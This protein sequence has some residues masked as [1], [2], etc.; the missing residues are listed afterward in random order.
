MR[1]P[2]PAVEIVEFSDPACPFAFSAEPFRWKLRWQFGHLIGCASRMV[3]LAGS[4]G[5]YLAKGMTAEIIAGIES[6]LGREHGMPIDPTVKAR[7]A[8]TR[9]A[10][11]AVVA[12]RIHAP[13]R[14]L[15]L[16]R[17]LRVRNFSGELLDDPATLAGAAADAGI[18]PEALAA[19]MSGADVAAAV[20]RDMDD[21]RHPSP[22]ALALDHKLA[23]WGGNGASGRRYTCPSLEISRVADGA[24]QSAPGL[25]PW[26][27]YE[28]LMANGL[29]SAE[30]RPSPRDV[31]EPPALGRDGPG[32]PGGRDGLRPESRRGARE[33]GRRRC[34]RASDRRRRLLD[35]RL[36]HRGGRRDGRASAALVDSSCELIRSCERIA[37]VSESHLVA[38]AVRDRLNAAREAGDSAA[39]I[40]RRAGCRPTA[41]RLLVLRALSS[42]DHVSA[43]EVLAHARASYPAINP[44]TVYRTLDALAEAGLVLCVD[45]GSGRRHYEI[46]REHRHHHVVCQRCGAVAHLHDASLAPLATALRADSGYRLV[47]DR[48]IAMPGVCP[49]CQASEEDGEPRDGDP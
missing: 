16:L 32:E 31:R 13:E 7:P 46:A 20:D 26:A 18:D 17:R 9:P 8:A 3:V 11:T 12:A 45:L 38:P 35:P 6:R 42:G 36:I 27:V 2:S 34:D 49:A 4:P 22:A 33:A 25:Q 43:E 47:L 48:E 28:T 29:P 23:D 10:C 30:R 14:Y 5:E 15:E 37:V 39:D 44:S 40:L 41:Q 1:Q 24:A 21:A 19:W